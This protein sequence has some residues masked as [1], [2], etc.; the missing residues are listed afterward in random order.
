M[1]STVCGSHLHSAASAGL[2]PGDRRA[3]RRA[4]VPGGSTQL[5]SLLLA[6]HAGSGLQPLL[7]SLTEP[8]FRPDP[9]HWAHLS[10]SWI[11]SKAQTV[12]ISG[13]HH[14]HAAA[15]SPG[16]DL[17]GQTAPRVPTWRRAPRGGTWSPGATGCMALPAVPVVTCH[18]TSTA[19]GN[20]GLDEGGGGGALH[21][22]VGGVAASPNVACRACLGQVG[23]CGNAATK[24]DK[25]TPGP[26]Q[27]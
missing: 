2:P 18:L 17:I 23:D 16:A 11:S 24:G 15:V 4:T 22:E 12:G 7:R 20:A 3:P 21:V 14:W 27:A 10:S 13:M 25:A 26:R 6:V 19:R 1:P 8:C 9:P 5:S